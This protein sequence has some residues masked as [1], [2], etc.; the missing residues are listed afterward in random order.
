MS[1][2]QYL[3]LGSAI[4]IAPHISREHA[5]II[6]YAIILIQLGIMVFG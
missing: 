1:M 3:G 2:I 6:A 4:I 5:Q